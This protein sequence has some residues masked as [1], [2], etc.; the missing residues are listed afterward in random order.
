M[1]AG[2]GKIAANAAVNRPVFFI[3]IYGLP[4]PT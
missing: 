3:Y 4:K 2:K 1:L